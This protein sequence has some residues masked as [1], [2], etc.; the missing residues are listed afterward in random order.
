M[1]QERE[2]K[3]K[4]H[5]LIQLD[6]WIRSGAYPSLEKMMHE[7]GVSRRTILRD[8]EFLRDRYGAPLE[9][10]K[11]RKG[12]Y[13]SDPTFVIQSVL[14]TEGDLF[15]I[16]TVMPLLEQYR[17]TPLEGSFRSIMSKVSELMPDTISVDTSF[18][19]KDIAF[20]TEPLPKID[21][22]VFFAIFRAVKGFETVT[23]G[24]RSSGGT[25]FKQR[26]FDCYRVLCKKGSW[27][28]IGF[29]HDAADD[30]SSTPGAIRVYALSRIRDVQFP[31]GRFSVPEGFE[32]NRHVD[33]SF[34]VWNNPEPPAE[35]ELVFSP[36]LANYITEREWHRDQSVE[37]NEDGSVTLKFR[38]NQ[39]QMV[40]SWVLGFASAVRVVRPDSLR[41]EIK[42]E[43]ARMA[44]LYGT[45]GAE[46]GGFAACAIMRNDE[47]KGR[48]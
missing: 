2:D 38:S 7:Y 18:L 30:A 20:I 35:D 32:L 4:T 15:T 8:M 6:K 3:F 1:A 33:L 34:G 39:K 27:Y 41:D 46:E 14:L 19:N 12:Y 10:D 24:Y 22:S 16:S 21:E 11:E 25:E 44:R 23:F 47:S 37:R 36:R 9:Y 45:G 40:F 26:T 43:I 31:G 28:V 17:N 5:R 29:D 13:Y 42:A 48:T